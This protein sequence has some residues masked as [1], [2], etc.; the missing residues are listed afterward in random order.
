VLSDRAYVRVSFIKVKESIRTEEKLLSFSFGSY[1]QRP[2]NTQPECQVSFLQEY[3][4]LKP[5]YNG[6]LLTHTHNQNV[7]CLSYKNMKI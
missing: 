4:D 2:G 6:K 7:K 5:V 3:E 1:Y